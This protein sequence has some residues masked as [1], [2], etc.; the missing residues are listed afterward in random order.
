LERA[1]KPARV[2]EQVRSAQALLAKTT[3]L[4]ASLR[5]QMN[6]TQEMIGKAR[7]TMQETR[8]VLNR[9][10]GASTEEP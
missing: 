10:A 7:R 6:Q 8:A 9:R 4:A 2:P 5:A 1:R 3:A